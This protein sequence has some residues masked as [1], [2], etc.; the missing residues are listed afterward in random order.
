MANTAQGNGDGIARSSFDGGATWSKTQL[1]SKGV[2]LGGPIAAT[3]SGSVLV[4]PIND[5]PVFVRDKKTGS[6]AK[7]AA[8]EGWH[9]G[10]FVVDG[11]DV[12]LAGVQASSTF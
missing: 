6:W 4:P 1:V 8:G 11:D 10:P 5:A 9:A 2:W 7:V 12:V 3:K